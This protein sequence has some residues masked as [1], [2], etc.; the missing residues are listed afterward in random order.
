VRPSGKAMAT[1]M[2]TITTLAVLG[3]VAIAADPKIMITAKH[4]NA[5]TVHMLSRATHASKT[6]RKVVA[7]QNSRET[8]SATTRIMLVAVLGTA[9]TAVESKLSKHIANCARAWIAPRR[10]PRN[11]LARQ[12]VA[13][14]PNSSKTRIV[15]TRTIIVDVTGT[16]VTV[17][18]SPTMA[19]ST[20]NIASYVNVWTPTIK[21]TVAVKEAVNFQSTKK[22][23]TVTTKTTTVVAST[24]AVIAV[25]KPTRGLSKRPIARY[26]SVWIPKHNREAEEP[27]APQN[28]E[29]PRTKGM[30]SATTTTTIAV[31]S[32]TA[33]IAVSKPTRGLSK[34]P[35]ARYASVR[36]PRDC[37]Q[38]A[39]PLAPQNAEL[40]RTKGMASATTP[41]TTAVV[42][43]MV[44]IAVSKPTRGL[45]KRPTAKYV[46]AS[47]LKESK[48]QIID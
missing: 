29:L 15:T 21:A 8:G 36:I 30:V 42:R 18:R 11:V 37:R 13:L 24:T 31:A 41:T 35:I 3:M 10:R 25:S 47:I 45:S 28:A 44:V 46:R 22:M 27:L 1:V 43:T 7:P 6:S 5:S 48:A 26:A 2:T 9:V 14:P 23:A 17:A 33:V 38:A 19:L 40:P 34:R 16:G 20:Q 39:E 32:T 4:V 12:K